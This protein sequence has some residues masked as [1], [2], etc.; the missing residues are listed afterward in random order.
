M[1]GTFFKQRRLLWLALMGLVAAQIAGIL[2]AWQPASAKISADPADEIVYIDKAGVIRVI[3]YTGDPK[4]EWASP[5]GGWDTLELGDFDGDGDMEIVAARE[6]NGVVH[7][8]VFDPVVSSGASN[9]DRRING[10]PWDILFETTLNGEEP[11]VATGNFDPAIPADEFVVAVLEG[12]VSRMVIYNANSLRSNG[13]PSGRDWKIHINQLMNRPYD[14]V[15]SGDI[16]DNGVDEIVVVDQKLRAGSD[17]QA[18]FDVLDPTRALER[19]TGKGSTQDEFK[20]AAVG[21]I[22]AGK[23]AEVAVTKSVDRISKASIIVYEMDADKELSLN[24]EWAFVPQVDWAFLADISGNGDKELFMLRRFNN[25][26][27]PDIPRMLMRD[28]WGDD[29]SK[30]PEIELPLDSD[31]GYRVGAGGD[32]DG[33]GREEIVIM[34]DNNIR[35]YLSPHNR[36]DRDIVD[37]AVDTNRNTLKVGNLDAVG[38]VFGPQFGSDKS[39]ISASVPVG[40]IS[41]A[42]TI[43]IANISTP[44]S[45]AFFLGAAVPPWL[46]VTPSNG[47]TPT[48]LTVTIDATNLAIG[49]YTSSIVIQTNNT[50]VINRP[51]TIDVEV[52]VTPAVLQPASADFV[53][54]PC[55]LPFTDDDAIRSMAVNIGGTRD[56]RFR[57]AILEIPEVSDAV[58]GLNGPISGGEVT[59]SGDIVLYDAQGS[60]ITVPGPQTGEV[61]IAST[62]AITWAEQISWITSVTSEDDRVPTTMNIEVDATEFGND[63]DRASALLIFVADTRAGTPPDNVYISS[64]NLLCAQSRIMLPLTQR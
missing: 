51:L 64:I 57:V 55:T 22:R 5:T 29:K 23:G 11:S 25:R 28:D 6:E 24:K 14:F 61:S 17:K 36:V 34:R 52:E 16:T 15:T 19:I 59:E 13:K 43:D 62:Q 38:F 60:S 49:K 39:K 8:T 56:L 9:P 26:S 33:D 42:Y 21:Q 45:I 12:G 1:N 63:F 37:F 35:V 48:R 7:I 31:G 53:Y 40:T 4:V 41:P 3:D 18:G 30:H 44:D 54:L 50:L 32:I 2:A 20:M 46:K 10:I 58:A 47:Q 27:L